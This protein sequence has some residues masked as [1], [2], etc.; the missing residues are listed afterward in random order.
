MGMIVH[1]K[2]VF[3]GQDMC[4]HCCSTPHHTRLYGPAT[5]WT[6]DLLWPS[7]LLL[8]N[9]ILTYILNKH[10]LHTCNRWTLY[11]V[12]PQRCERRTHDG[13]GKPWT[14]SHCGRVLR[15][16]YIRYDTCCKTGYYTTEL[17]RHHRE[18]GTVL[19]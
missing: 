11:E 6:C 13:N 4:V 19:I 9:I 14:T 5:I 7:K 1:N 8:R 10:N 2:V 3:P 16:E 12:Q 17:E 18:T 15:D